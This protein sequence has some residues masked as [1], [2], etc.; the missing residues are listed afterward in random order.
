MK[1]L[2]ASFVLSLLGIIFGFGYDIKLG[3]IFNILA[4][5]VFLGFGGLKALR[6][7]VQ[8]EFGIDIFS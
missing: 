2:T 4:L 5:Y 6:E 3:T 1:T 8:K 7:F